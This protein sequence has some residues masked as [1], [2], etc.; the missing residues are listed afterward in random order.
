MTAEVQ[1]ISLRGRQGQEG[2]R[3]RRQG[4]ARDRRLPA[5]AG[6]A[7]GRAQVQDAARAASPPATGKA[8]LTE[9]AG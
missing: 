6:M 1:E 9:A 7:A 2:T 4:A 3:G 8:P 5:A